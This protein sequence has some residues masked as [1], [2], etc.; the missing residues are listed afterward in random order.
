MLH[1]CYCSMKFGGK[2]TKY[3]TVIAKRIPLKT[4]PFPLFWL[5]SVNHNIAPA[6]TTTNDDI[7]PIK[8][9]KS[10]IS[11]KYP[12]IRLAKSASGLR[13]WNCIIISSHIN[14]ARIDNIKSSKY[15]DRFS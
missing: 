1:K 10:Q 12:A 9:K 3:C 4:N 5:T 14:H 6:R 15:S 13:I 11:A 2:N 8:I 7:L